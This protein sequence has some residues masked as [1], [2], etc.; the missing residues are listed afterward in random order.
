MR[1]T[2][3]LNNNNFLNYSYGICHHNRSISVPYEAT[4]GLYYN[5]KLVPKYGFSP[6]QCPRWLVLVIVWS[7]Y[8]WPS[9]SPFMKLKIFLSSKVLDYFFPIQFTVWSTCCRLFQTS[10]CLQSLRSFHREQLVSLLKKGSRQ[11]IK[12]ICFCWHHCDLVFLAIADQTRCGHWSKDD[13]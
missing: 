7:L 2:K 13:P 8:F 1:K 4:Q 11:C 6:F 5:V 9:D 3:Q 12:K 10:E